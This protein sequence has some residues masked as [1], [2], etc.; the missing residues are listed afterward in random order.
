MDDLW[1]RKQMFGNISNMIKFCK[2]DEKKKET[3]QVWLFD[4][5][6]ALEWKSEEFKD[7]LELLDVWNYTFEENLKWE[8]ESIGFY[9]SGHPLDWLGRYCSRRGCNVEKLRKSMDELLEEDK[10]NNPD[11]YIRKEMDEIKKLTETEEEDK[12][13]KKKKKQDRKEEKVQAVWVIIELR[14]IITKWW[15]PMMFI[16]WEWFDYDFEVVL[17]SKDIDKYVEKLEEAKI[18]IVTWTLN[19]NFE[20]WRKSINVINMQVISISS[21]R[22]Q[23]KDLWLFDNKKRYINRTLN[24]VIEENKNLEDW[25]SET[26]NLE[27]INKYIV[28]IPDNSKKNDLHELKEFLLWQEKW[29]IKIFINLKWQEIFTKIWLNSLDELNKWTKKKW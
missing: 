21:V 29:D 12:K 9:V 6:N 28:I 16:K 10:K 15:K 18:I 13:E 1:E 3:N 24:K 26:I 8:K 25:Q 22:N 17:F 5:F 14:K 4:H 23:A 7:N 11:K 27:V 2:K 19:I 20:Y